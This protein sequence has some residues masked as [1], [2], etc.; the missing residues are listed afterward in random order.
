[1]KLNRLL[2]ATLVSSALMT[3][4]AMAV[5]TGTITFN[6]AITDSTCDVSVAGGGA[7]GTVNLP[8]VSA[9]SIPAAG[10][11]N[12]TTGFV[13]SLTN[14][15]GT[16]LNTAKAFFQAGMTV[17]S[18]TGRL[19]NTDPTG[20]QFVSLQLRDGSD[21]S[22]IKVG[23]QSQTGPSAIG[24]HDISSG[25]ANLPYLVEYYAEQDNAVTPGAVTS[26]VTY[27]IDYQ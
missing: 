11:V 23:D 19:L 15:S 27:N 24:Y 9:S 2:L 13:M 22:V 26:L 5:D 14:C 17:D 21:N 25:A 7:D 4:G 8:T 3:T 20:A 10:D 16:S 18:N 6:G 1:M 12:G